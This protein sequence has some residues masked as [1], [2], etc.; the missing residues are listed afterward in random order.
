MLILKPYQAEKVAELKSDFLKLLSKEK[1]SSMVFEAPT[2]SGKTI[3]MQ[4]FLRQVAEIPKNR[5]LAFIWLS[6]GDL[7]RQSKESFERNLEGS[8]LIFSELSNIKT[9][10][11]RENEVLFINWEKLKQKDSKTGEWKVLAMKDNERDENIPKYM[12]NTRSKWLEIVLIIDESSRELDTAK[13]QELIGEYFRPIIQIE[14]SAT[15][16]SIKY[17]KKITVDM[18]EVIASGM[19][20]K[21]ILVNEDIDIVRE[22]EFGDYGT[23]RLIISKAR[24]KQIEL[25]TAYEAVSDTPIR[26]LLLIQLPNESATT[27]EIDRTKI[28]RVMRILQDDFD[29]TLA[30][31][32]LAIWLSDDKT[33]K[34]LVEIANSPVE[35]LLFK[36]AIAYGWDCPRAQILVMFRKIGSFTFEI[37]TIGRILRMPEQ[38][39]YENELLNRAFVYTDLEK[40][41]VMVHDTAKNMIK[42][43]VAVAKM[44]LYKPFSLPSTFASRGDYNDLGNSFYEVFFEYFL[45]HIMGG[46]YRKTLEFLGMERNRQIFE[47]LLD[48]KDL[49]ITGSLIKDGKILVDIDRHTGEHIIISDKHIDTR[50]E[51]E[52]IELQFDN[53][54]RSSVWPQFGNIA[55]S[56]KTIKECLFGLFERYIFGVEFSRMDIQK[57]VLKNKDQFSTWMNEIKDYYRPIRIQQVDDKTQAK[58]KNKTWSIPHSVGFSWEKVEVMASPKYIYTPGYIAFDSGIERDFATEYLDTSEEVVFWYKNGVQLDIYFGIKYELHGASRMFY[59]DFVVYFR[60]WAIGIFETKDGSTLTSAET[61]EKAEALEKYTL[62]MNAKGYRIISGVVKKEGIVGNSMFMIGKRW[63]F[64]LVEASSFEILNDDFV[65]TCEFHTD[66]SYAPEYIAEIRSKIQSLSEEKL[67]KEAEYALFVEEQKGYDAMDNT[68]MVEKMLDL[69]EIGKKIWELKGEIAGDV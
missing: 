12:E 7:S 32:R 3:M 50:Q 10:A 65:R 55:R 22:G 62:E 19:I 31:Q 36:Q 28:E 30:N 41:S 17:D 5:N 16:D 61:Q 40:N 25:A 20:K 18:S 15:P 58:F 64:D 8:K 51:E 23:D 27:T 35:V 47:K 13:A 56:Y 67:R 66:A 48:T 63:R 29:I 38:K 21:E 4:E 69:E 45:V 11:L 54:C 42:N 14:V 52:L 46:E 44:N 6:I 68:A 60:S 9:G 43:H 53:F 24:E 37:Q 2:G 39:H 59:P 34:D 57:L 33:N 49:D 1:P 26:P